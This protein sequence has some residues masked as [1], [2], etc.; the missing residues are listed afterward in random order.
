MVSPV[1]LAAQMK[2]LA[3]QLRTVLADPDTDWDGDYA[4]LIAHLRDGADETGHALNQVRDN[5]ADME[6]P[7]WDTVFVESAQAASGVFIARDALWEAAEAAKQGQVAI[8]EAI[9]VAV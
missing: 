2:A 3:T 5:V 1:E 7:E 8:Q 6:G 9:S 4:A